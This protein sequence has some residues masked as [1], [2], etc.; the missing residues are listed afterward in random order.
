[1]SEV[2]D[3]SAKQ[4]SGAQI[5]RPEAMSVTGMAAHVIMF[6]VLT[7]LALAVFAPCVLFP[8]Y[9]DVEGAREYRHQMALIL[10][11]LNAQE[12]KNQSRINGLHDDPLVNERIAR[13]ELNYQG[14][15]EQIVRVTAQELAALRVEPPDLT[16]SGPVDFGT[17][18]GPP[19]WMQA[20]THWLPAWPYGRLFGD[21]T[22][23]MVLMMMA[24]GLLVSAFVLYGRIPVAAQSRQGR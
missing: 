20:L 15:Q 16:K 19:H 7:G 10:D 14:E 9:Q 8:V 5:S 11:D 21:P 22:N 3:K 12:A 2:N 4:P 17:G 1:M 13:R 18:G 24:A 23:R 6:W